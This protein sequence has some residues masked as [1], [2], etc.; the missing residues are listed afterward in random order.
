[1]KQTSLI[2][3]SKQSFLEF[4]RERNAHERAMLTA[5]VAVIIFALIYIMLINP[6]LSGRIRLNSELPALRQ[7]VAQLQALVKEAVTLSGK[8]VPTVSAI[9][10][11]GIAAELANKGLKP[12]TSTLSNDG[13]AQVEFS[14]ASFAAFLDW[15]NEMQKKSR[16]SVVN[17][18][19][20]VL[21]KPDTVNATVILR[22]QRNE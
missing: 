3:L 12:K 8:P 7:Q 17:A 9:T 16:L 11:E 4:W 18:N 21:P 19:I 14:S 15:L 5:A 2:N 13:Q 10:E 6:P 20:V 1:M 22:Q